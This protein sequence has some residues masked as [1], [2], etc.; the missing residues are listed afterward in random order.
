MPDDNETLDSSSN[1]RPKSDLTRQQ[2]WAHLTAEYLND[3]PRQFKQIKKML[4]QKDYAAIK[5]HAHRIKG[6]SAT[7]RLGDISKSAAQLQHIAD[8]QNPNTIAAIINKLTQLVKLQIEKLDS[9]TL[10][11]IDDSERFADG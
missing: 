10:S 3:L 11:S 4:S 7:Y 1:Q 5:K 9:L 6:T 8:T 2:L